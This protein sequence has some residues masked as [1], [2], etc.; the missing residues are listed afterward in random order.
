MYETPEDLA[1]LQELLDRSQAGAG[2]HLADIMSP[3]R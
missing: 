1:A 3:E 2:A